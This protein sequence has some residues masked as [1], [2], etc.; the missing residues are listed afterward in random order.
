MAISTKSNFLLYVN[1]S[2][3]APSNVTNVIVGTSANSITLTDD[4][5]TCFYCPKEFTAK[6]ISYK[7]NYGMTTGGNGKGWET[8]A[9]PF[10]V[11][12]ISHSSK[13]VLTPFASYQS[14][15]DQRPF[16]L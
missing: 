15:T 1:S 10:N 7:H 5:Y 2:S 4:T 14:G 8:I 6:T 3:Y 16:W 11:K 13:G 12:K 9:L